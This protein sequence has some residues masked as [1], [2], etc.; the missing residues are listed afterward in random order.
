MMLTLIK[1]QKGT[2]V[3]KEFEEKYGT[4]NELKR[5]YEETKNSLF[6]VDYENWKYLKDN[7]DRELKSSVTKITNKLA[8]SDLEMKILDFIK[9]EHP[10]SIRELARFLD[11][12]IKTI[13]PKMKELEKRGLIKFKKGNKNSK[14]P[15]LSYDK[16][17][18]AI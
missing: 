18:I 4:I 15:Y 12:D 11:K 14:I 9:N 16:I 1:K 3:L 2:E 10:K 17:E 5:L 13:Q 8:L 6:L 7:P